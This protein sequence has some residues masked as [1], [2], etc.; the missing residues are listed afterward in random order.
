MNDKLYISAE[1]CLY[2]DA[3]KDQN[4]SFAHSGNLRLKIT[5]K[6]KLRILVR[7]IEHLWSY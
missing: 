1:Y 3:D 2:K 5:L 4:F 7:F 6:N